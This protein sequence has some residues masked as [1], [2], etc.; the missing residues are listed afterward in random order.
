MITCGWC[1]K[2][3][4]LATSGNDGTVRIWNVTK[5][6]YT[7]QQTC[8]FNKGW[9]PLFLLIRLFSSPTEMWCLWSSLSVFRDDT[10]DECMGNLGSPGDPNLAPVAW[11]V[12][13][14]YLAA[15][16]E[17]I[18][19]I[20][21]VNGESLTITIY[22]TVRQALLYITL[23][24]SVAWSFRIHSNMLNWCPR[25]NIMNVSRFFDE[26]KVWKKT[27][28]HIE[29]ISIKYHWFDGTDTIKWE[30]NWAK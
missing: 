20:W 26:W 16:M 28:K 10:S 8:V 19:N 21:Q 3:G 29:S 15:A 2:K 24:F 27:F 9:V 30:V 6:L 22:T 12:S 17:K 13:G 4:L 18:V 25:N 5:N 11:S 23:V 1:S 7:L 14:K